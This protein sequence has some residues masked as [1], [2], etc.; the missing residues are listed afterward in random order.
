M[1]SKLGLFAVLFAI[2]IFQISCLDETLDDNNE[3]QMKIFASSLEHNKLVRVTYLMKHNLYIR[4][5]VLKKLF[6]EG[7]EWS[8]ALFSNRLRYIHIR[9]SQDETSAVVNINL[10]GN[11]VYTAGSGSTDD[12]K[13]SHI[14]AWID[15]CN[16]KLDPKARFF[17]RYILFINNSRSILFHNY[18]GIALQD[19]KVPIIG[20]PE[21]DAKG[22]TIVSHSIDCKD[23]YKPTKN[24]LRLHHH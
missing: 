8:P 19:Q 5:N 22:P 23:S 20:N 7:H 24:P 10:D 1:K 6:E 17:N 13:Q 2:A 11:G 4:T 14:N 21:E 16:R 3:K 18:I 15:Y 9:E 12:S